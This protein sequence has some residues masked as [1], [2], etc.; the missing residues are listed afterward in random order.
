MLLSVR[1]KEPLESTIDDTVTGTEV[2]TVTRTVNT[3]CFA[4]TSRCRFACVSSC[5]EGAGMPVDA[6]KSH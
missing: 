1:A 4:F 5:R 6:T 2:P 3:V